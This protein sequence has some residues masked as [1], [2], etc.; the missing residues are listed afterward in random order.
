MKDLQE[1]AIGKL[2]ERGVTI[3]DI[4]AGTQTF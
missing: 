2:A 4:T 1:A 3:A